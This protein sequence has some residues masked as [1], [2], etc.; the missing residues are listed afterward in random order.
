MRYVIVS[1]SLLMLLR[2]YFYLQLDYGVNGKIVE[3]ERT[4][5]IQTS[6]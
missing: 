3:F 1:L 6:L 4:I 2:P 5:V